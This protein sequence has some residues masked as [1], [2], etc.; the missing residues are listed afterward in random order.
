M[1][2]KVYT[3]KGIQKSVHSSIIHRHTE[4]GTVQVLVKGKMDS[5]WSI[6][7][8]EY[9]T[10]VRMNELQNMQQRRIHLINIILSRRKQDTLGYIIYESTYIKFKN[11]VN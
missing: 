3:P 5:S 11:R 1:C 4:L 7:A 2:A 10:V 9:Y 8:E 6:S